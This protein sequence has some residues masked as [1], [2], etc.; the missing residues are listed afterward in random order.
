M[1]ALK[2]VVTVASPAEHS[3]SEPIELLVDTGAT[4]TVLPTEVWQRIGLEA[5]ITRQLRTADG[6]L[7][8]REQGLAFLE[9]N[10][11]RG[12]VPVV[13]GGEGDTPVLGV[14]SLEIL[15]LAFDP[16]RGELVPSEH[17]YLCAAEDNRPKIK[18]SLRD[19]MTNW[20]ES[21]LPFFAKLGTALRNYSR[22]FGVPPRNCC[23][24]Y[25]QP[26]C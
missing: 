18:P 26:G 2:T 7:L 11:S 23:G 12:T 14:T 10:G 9:I 21:D 22:R 24:N 13:Q 17:L 1:G 15:G 5:E 3:K 16:V 19:A 4:F 20:R 6:R 8:E 25:G